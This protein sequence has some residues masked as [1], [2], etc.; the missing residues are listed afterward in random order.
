MKYLPNK[1]ACKTSMAFEYHEKPC[2][3]QKSN[4]NPAF[5]VPDGIAIATVQ[6]H[7]PVQGD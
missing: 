3:R 2:L 5:L 6:P 4:T 1:K 7:A